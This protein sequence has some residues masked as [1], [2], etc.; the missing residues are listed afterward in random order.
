MTNS[1]LQ[2]AKISRVIPDSIGFDVGDAIVSINGICPRDLIDYQFLCA[3]DVL[4]IEVQDTTGK[5][6]NSHFENKR[7]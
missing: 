5:T 1:S 3:D 4:E 7:R 6:S 2:P